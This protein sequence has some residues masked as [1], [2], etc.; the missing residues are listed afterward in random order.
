MR[1]LVHVSSNCSAPRLNGF[2]RAAQRG[3]VFASLLLFLVLF[4]Y[5]Y[6]YSWVLPAS[7]P[8]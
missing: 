5:Y 1:T 6:C 7:A 8:A 3:L 4:S 2:Y